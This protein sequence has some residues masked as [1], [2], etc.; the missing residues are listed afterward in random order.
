MEYLALFHTQ[1]GAIKFHKALGGKGIEARM[2]PVPRKLSSSCGI[3]VRF[4]YED[5][6]G[7]LVLVDIEKIYKINGPEYQLVYD[8][9]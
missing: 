3:A 8:G 2:L 4:S 7:R 1:S 6:I 9:E 5:D